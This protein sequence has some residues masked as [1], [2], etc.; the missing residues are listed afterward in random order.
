MMGVH[1]IDESS[2]LDLLCFRLHHGVFHI[3]HGQHLIDLI[4]RIFL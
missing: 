3:Y 1:C 2:F 4:G